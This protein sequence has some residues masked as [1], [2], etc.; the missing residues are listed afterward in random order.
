MGPSFFFFFVSDAF[1]CLISDNAKTVASEVL[2]FLL[3]GDDNMVDK[4]YTLVY[5]YLQP[6]GVE[7]DVWY[8]RT[9]VAQFTQQEVQATKEIAKLRILVEN[10]IL[11]EHFYQ[12]L[13][14]RF[15]VKSVRLS[16]DIVSVCTAQRNSFVPLR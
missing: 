8:F 16:F 7:F 1:L 6:R 5:A 15:P 4:S 10:C 3:L 9:G 12:I 13:Q 14:T 11:R 2:D